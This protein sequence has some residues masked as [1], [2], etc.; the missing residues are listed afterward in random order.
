MTPSRPSDVGLADVS[1]IS[2]SGW[3]RLRVLAVL[4]KPRLAFF[5]VCSGVS[6]MLVTQPEPSLILATTLG[7]TLA[8]GGAL[9]LNQWWE[10]EPDRLMRRTADRPLPA[11]RVT[12]RT[13]LT[14]SLA[15]SLGGCA[16]LGFFTTPLAAAVAALIIVLYG[17]IY[18]PLKRRTRWA[19][20]IGAI[21]GALPP[22]L[23]A[24]AGAAP[25]NRAAWALA[26]AILFWQMPHFFAIGWMYRA[27][28]R[29]AGFKLLPVVDGDGTA[30]A[31][32]S[33]VHSL[34]LGAAV[35]YPWARGF[36]GPCYGVVGCVTALVMLHASLA[37]LRA[38]RGE[39]DLPARRL[40]LGTIATLPLMMIALVAEALV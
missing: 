27:D 38:P 19:T 4:T 6:G 8:A 14:F 32:W 36:V 21:S 12:A 10:R 34:L 13:A 29:R 7:I 40:F 2:I 35:L 28:Y 23:G 30:T 31:A 24:A 37:M 26:A 3:E 1:R 9:S 22:L 5:S 39:R 18:T 33:M 16:V 17:L 11:G 25:D 20:E 15:L